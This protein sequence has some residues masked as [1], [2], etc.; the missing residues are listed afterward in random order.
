VHASTSPDVANTQIG[1]FFPSLVASVVRTQGP[2][3]G[4]NPAAYMEAELQSTLTKGL[5]QLCKHKP[6]NPLRWLAE[7]LHTNNPNKPHV[8]LP[9]SP[10]KPLPQPKAKA[11]GGSRAPDT[12]LVLVLDQSMTLTDPSLSSVNPEVTNDLARLMVTEC[13]FT[14]I[15]IPTL[16]EDEITQQSQVGVELDRLRKTGSTESIYMLVIHASDITR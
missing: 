11:R 4:V 15:D 1:F 5:T 7:W 9:P 16:L 6:P 3:Q 8:A 12:E 13:S 10:P 14:Y 2:P